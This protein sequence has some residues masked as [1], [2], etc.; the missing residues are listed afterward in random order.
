MVEVLP[1]LY[2]TRRVARITGEDGTEDLAYIDPNSP[3]AMQKIQHGSRRGQDRS[4]T[5]LLADMTLS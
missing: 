2:D 5:L 4:I 1:R 3:Q